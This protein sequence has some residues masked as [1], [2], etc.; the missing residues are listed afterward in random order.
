M[1]KIQNSGAETILFYPLSAPKFDYFCLN[2]RNSGA[3]TW[4]FAP[5]SAL[6]LAISHQR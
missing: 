3:E 1:P 2:T 4:F 6:E 5:L